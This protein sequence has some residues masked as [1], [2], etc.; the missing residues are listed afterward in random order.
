[1]ELCWEHNTVF[2]SPKYRAVTYDINFLFYQRPVYR[3]FSAIQTFMVTR[4]SHSLSSD[5]IH[6]F[7]P[8]CHYIRL[9]IHITIPFT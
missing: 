7:Y 2:V 1:M 9:S 8:L 3:K 6:V 5:C 4:T